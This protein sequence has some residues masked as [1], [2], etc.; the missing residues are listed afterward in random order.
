MRCKYVIQFVAYHVKFTDSPL[1]FEERALY[2]RQNRTVYLPYTFFFYGSNSALRWIFSTQHTH[3]FKK[4]ENTA[5]IST[6]LNIHTH[7][8]FTPQVIISI[9]VSVDVCTIYISRHLFLYSKVD[10][11]DDDDDASLI[12]SVDMN[13]YMKFQNGFRYDGVEN[14]PT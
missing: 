10:D 5:H 14:F 2:H 1:M 7:T 4:R 11:D 12:C 6:E 3:P 9:K 13:D 8:P